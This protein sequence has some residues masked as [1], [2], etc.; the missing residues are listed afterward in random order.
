MHFL[1]CGYKPWLILWNECLLS[2]NI[3]AV[4]FGGKL[5][6]NKKFIILSHLKHFCW[7]M[8][9]GKLFR[10]SVLTSVKLHFWIVRSNLLPMHALL[11][12]LVSGRGINCAQLL[13]LELKRKY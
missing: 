11:W 2:F 13:V 3:K 7:G 6:K 4:F 9:M 1:V 8:E 5:A 12:I 10:P